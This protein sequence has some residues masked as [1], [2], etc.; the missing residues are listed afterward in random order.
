MAEILDMTARRKKNSGKGSGADP[1]EY[2]RRKLK[3]NRKR[4]RDLGYM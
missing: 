4:L 2:V 1:D 3:G